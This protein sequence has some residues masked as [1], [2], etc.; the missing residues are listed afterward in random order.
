MLSEAATVLKWKH[1]GPIRELAMNQ[2][3]NHTFVAG[4]NSMQMTVMRIL[5][6][7]LDKVLTES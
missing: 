5:I 7:V 4:G 1:G 2:W 3:N 6:I